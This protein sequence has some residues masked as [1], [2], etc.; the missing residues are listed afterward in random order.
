MNSECQA[1]AKAPEVLLPPQLISETVRSA[2][3]WD[4]EQWSDLSKSL[5][6]SLSFVCVNCKLY[7]VSIFL[8]ILFQSGGVRRA[9]K[10]HCDLLRR[11]M[12]A[13]VS[14]RARVTMAL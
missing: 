1:K 13:T 4:S 14:D 5:V 9:P 8:Q 3:Q 11:Q 7:V 12:D 10:V 6:F 2:G